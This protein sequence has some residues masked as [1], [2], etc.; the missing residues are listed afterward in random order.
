M[1]EYEILGTYFVVDNCELKLTASSERLVN[2][3]MYIVRNIMLL[4]S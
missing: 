3:I 1:E 2:I 4:Q